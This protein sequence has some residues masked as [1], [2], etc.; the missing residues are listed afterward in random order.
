MPIHN[1]SQ[2]TQPP[3][4]TVHHHVGVNPALVHKVQKISETT[5]SFPL[6]SQKNPVEKAANSR[7]IALR[8]YET[9]DT[10]SHINANKITTIGG[11]SIEKT[12]AFNVLVNSDKVIITPSKLTAY[13]LNPDHPVGKHK[14]RVFQRS[15]GYNQKNAD[16]LMSKIQLGVKCNTAIF[17]KADKFGQRATV[18]MPITGPNGNTATVRTCWIYNSSSTVPKL[19]TLYIND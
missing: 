3:Q 10:D 11:I 12:G 13:A 2:Y 17:T 4:P 15:L 1:Y 6:L 9:S 5:E 8:N 7:P 18:D 19:T 16:D 14:A